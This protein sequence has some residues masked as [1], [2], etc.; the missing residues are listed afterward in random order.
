MILAYTLLG[1]LWAVSVNDTV[2]FLILLPVCLLLVPLSISAVGGLDE[3][4]KSAPPDYFAFPSK[5]LPVHYMIAYLVLLIH[6]QNTNPI[7]QRYF[8]VRNESE[9]KKVSLL[10]SALF[11]VGLLFWAV[12][13]MAARILYP[14]LASQLALPNPDEG[15]FVVIALNLL[16]HGLMGLLVAAMFAASLSSLDSVY[17]LLAGIV[18]KDIYQRLFNRN[19]SDKGL[20]RVSQAA[21]LAIGL[22]VIELC[23]LMVKYG[24]GAFSVMM[25]ISSL[26]C[27]PLATPMLLGFLYRKAPGWS[28]M[29][30]FI[31]SAT[32]A[33]VFAFYTPL[34]D[35]LKSLGPWVDFSVSSLMIASV[36]IIAF[37]I[38]PYLF[39]SKQ[40]EQ[41]RISSFF[42]KLHTPV[43]EKAEIKAADIDRTSIARFVGKIAI[44]IGV[45]VMMFA[46]I[47]A[48]VNARLINIGLGAVICVFGIVMVSARWK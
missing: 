21:T 37:F 36:G 11:L 43:D 27:T 24:E 41:E 19:M 44:V 26:T 42:T 13:P 40:D 4:V 2:Q 23:L 17:N 34:I 32:T 31:C 45:L 47:P 46:L 39:S 30:S 38:S 10:C 16:P 14:D 28:C 9:A 1:G 12:P 5:T 25:K 22:I 48:S 35:Y 18:S 15:A 7:A 8:S 3:I 29:L 6:G 33:V 20:L